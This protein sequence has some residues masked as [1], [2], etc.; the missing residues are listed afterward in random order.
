MDWAEFTV[1]VAGTTGVA[2]GILGGCAGILRERYKGLNEAAQVSL[3]R[4][5]EDNSDE[6]HASEFLMKLLADEHGRHDG[7]MAEE[8]KRG[9]AYKEA[10]SDLKE[11]LKVAKTAID[12]LSEEVEELRSKIK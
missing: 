6:M 10:M 12:K 11:E 1:I 4:A 3:E 9:D 8:R 7:L 2:T 5:R